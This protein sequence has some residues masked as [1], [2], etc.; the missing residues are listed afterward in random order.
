MHPAQADRYALRVSVNHQ[1]AARAN[2]VRG[3]PLAEGQ[4]AKRPRLPALHPIGELDHL[5]VAVEQGHVG[6][7]HTK[8]FVQLGPD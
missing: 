7:G 4:W 3:E 2:H 5:V 8:D 1:W 6:D